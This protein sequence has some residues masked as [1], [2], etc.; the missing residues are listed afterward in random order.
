MGETLSHEEFVAGFREGRIKVEVERKG[1]V[2]LVSAR[3]LLPLV[4]L[5]VLGLAVAL[6]IAGYLVA[7]IG[8]F[9]AALALRFFIRA[10]SPGFVLS[11]ALNDRR[12]YE[13]VRDAGML[14][15]RTT[16]RP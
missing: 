14:Q 6:A 5:P 2:R 3:L 7:G 4:L 10:S 11:N 1:A 9:V 12:F 16:D 13:K 15:I 8:I